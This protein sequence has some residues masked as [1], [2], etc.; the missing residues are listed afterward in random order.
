MAKTRAT[1]NDEK[2]T[3]LATKFKGHDLTLIE[4]KQQLSVI[5]QFMLRVD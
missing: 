3:A 2:I 1:T 4:M 5:A